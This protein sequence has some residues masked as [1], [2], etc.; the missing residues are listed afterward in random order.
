MRW[1]QRLQMATTVQA[2]RRSLSVSFTALDIWSIVSPSFSLLWNV[3]PLRGFQRTPRELRKLLV[4]THSDPLSYQIR[5]SSLRIGNCGQ[6]RRMSER[7]LFVF[8]RARFAQ[9][10]QIPLFYSQSATATLHGKR[11]LDEVEGRKKVVSNLTI[12]TCGFI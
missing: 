8:F 4:S 5:R 1:E 3:V 12:I 10:S 2:P 6:C 7:S 11:H 9:A